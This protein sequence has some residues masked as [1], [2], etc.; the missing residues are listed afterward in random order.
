VVLARLQWQ[1]PGD[2]LLLPPG[3]V[4]VWRVDLQGDG[5][6]IERCSALLS[7]DGRQRAARYHFPRDQRR[8][9]VGRG[10]LRCLLGRYLDRSP[11]SLQ[12]S[13]GPRGKPIL[14]GEQLSFNVSHSQDL[15]L[16]ACP[17]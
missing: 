15:A 6:R 1:R 3:E 7:A 11:V 14:V 13:Y 12:F 8:F 9:I 17:W 5:D 16:I 10:T 2:R 4:H